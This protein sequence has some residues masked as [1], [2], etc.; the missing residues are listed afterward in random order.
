MTAQKQQR[1][2]PEW[3]SYDHIDISGGNRGVCY[4]S[5]PCSILSISCIDIGCMILWGLLGLTA[6]Q[7][8]LHLLY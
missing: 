8:P 5:R 3:V 2:T 4:A 1:G 7:Y 6:V